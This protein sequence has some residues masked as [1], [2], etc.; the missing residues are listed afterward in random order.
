MVILETELLLGRSS[1]V[2]NGLTGLLLGSILRCPSTFFSAAALVSSTFWLAAFLASSTCWLAAS[3]AASFTSVAASPTCSSR[4]LT[5]AS[6]STSVTAATAAT[7]A[8]L[9]PTTAFTL[10]AFSFR[11]VCTLA[12][13]SLATSGFSLMNEA[14]FSLTA[15]RASC[16]LATSPDSRMSLIASMSSWAAPEAIESIHSY[17]VNSFTLLGLVSTRCESDGSNS[18]Y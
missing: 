7:A 9:S 15:A 17:G 3:T 4:P 11:K 8:S 18:H 6:G 16:N 12:T 14:I 5:T 1:S 13:Y 2:V 10:S